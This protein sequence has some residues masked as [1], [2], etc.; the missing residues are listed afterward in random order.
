M[1]QIRNLRYRAPNRLRLGRL[2]VSFRPQIRQ[3]NHVGSEL[4]PQVLHFFGSSHQ[5][6]VLRHTIQQT[7]KLTEFD[8]GEDVRWNGR[9]RLELLKFCEQ[10]RVSLMEFS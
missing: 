7:V 5:D 4:L 8:A 10:K 6:G 2:L 9:L 1:Q 3:L